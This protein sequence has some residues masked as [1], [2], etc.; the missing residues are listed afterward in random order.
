MPQQTLS[1]ELQLDALLAS[2][3]EDAF[4]SA[5]DLMSDLKKESA[6]LQ[7]QLG[8]LGSEHKELDK[9]GK[10]TDGFRDEMS[11]IAGSPDTGDEPCDRNGLEKHVLHFRKVQVSAHGHCL[12]QTLLGF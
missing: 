2:G 11:F 8:T 9:L 12:S 4:S 1:T 5:S 3:F 6:Q 10:D 7:K